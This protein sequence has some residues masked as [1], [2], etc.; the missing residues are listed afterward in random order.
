MKPVVV[1]RLFIM[2]LMTGTNYKILWDPT[3]DV[4]F[5][6]V[7]NHIVGE[8][9]RSWYPVANNDYTIRQ[10]MKDDD[11][12]IRDKEKFEELKKRLKS[13]SAPSDMESIRTEDRQ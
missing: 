6:R 5:V 4:Y 2:G 12:R 13:G 10:L 3:S 7:Q 8:C 1:A 9:R 11:L